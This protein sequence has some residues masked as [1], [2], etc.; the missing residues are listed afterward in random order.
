MSYFKHGNDY[1]C[2]Y[3]VGEEETIDGTCGKIARCQTPAGYWLCAEHYDRMVWCTE[4]E[5]NAAEDA[6]TACTEE[7]WAE[8]EN[9]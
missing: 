5:V 4:D 6:E 9:L 1:W 7:E 3:P 2:S 8:I